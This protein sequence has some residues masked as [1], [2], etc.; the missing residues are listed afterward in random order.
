MIPFRRWLTRDPLPWRAR[1]MFNSD[2]KID[3]PAGAPTPVAG[4]APRP[5]RGR[6]PS[7]ERDATLRRTHR[8]R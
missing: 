6:P 8:S 2:E 1:H 7:R 3:T 4:S 5:V